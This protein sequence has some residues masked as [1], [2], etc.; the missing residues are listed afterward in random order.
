MTCW[1]F[2]LRIAFAISPPTYSGVMRGDMKLLFFQL[3]RFLSVQSWMRA[4]LTQ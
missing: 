3:L 4:V 2:P 1:L